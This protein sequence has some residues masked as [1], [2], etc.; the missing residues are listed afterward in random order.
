VIYLDNNA[1]TRPA[2]EVVVAIEKSLR[3]NWGNPSSLYTGG[4]RAREAVELA[5]QQV[6]QLVGCSPREIILTSGGTESCNLALAGSLGGYLAAD[7]GKRKVIV[8]TRFEH[9]AVRECSQELSNRFVNEGAE[10]VWLEG[11]RDGVIDT[12]T[13][14]H[15]LQKRANE[16]AIVSVM[17]VN[18][19][20][21]VLQPIAQLGS[22]CRQYGVRFHTDATQWVGRMPTDLSSIEVD[23]L[24]LSAHKFQGPKGVGALYCRRG[25]MLRSAMIGGPQERDRRGG[26]ENV[27]GIIGMGVAAELA[28]RWLNQTPNPWTDFEALRNQFEALVCAGVPNVIVLANQNLRVWNT[29]N[30]AFTNLEAEAVLVNLAKHGVAASAGA[31][32]SSGSLDPSPVLL[33]MGVAPEIAHGAVRFSISRNTTHKEIISA[34]NAVIE[35][36]QQL[37]RS[38]PTA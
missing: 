35:S 20:T 24:T 29:S 34:A 2:E 22:L 17:W 13:L 4:A 16:I 8:T 26:T 19:E 9:S 3:E 32:C 27:S 6:A 30:I 23:L 25:T 37:S 12:Q 36:V 28:L 1:T 14:E 31:A 10:V 7:H 5:R 15:L 33:A 18:N 21:G 38:M 11:G